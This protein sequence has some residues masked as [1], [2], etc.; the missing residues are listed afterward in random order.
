MLEHC[1]RSARQDSLAGYM[2]AVA[3]FAS[4]GEHHSSVLCLNLV[5]HQTR[6]PLNQLQKPKND[7]LEQPHFRVSI[8]HRLRTLQA[9][10]GVDCFRRSG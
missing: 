4:G 2:T 3:V 7:N 1:T 9:V 8:L 10:V 6:L 5:F